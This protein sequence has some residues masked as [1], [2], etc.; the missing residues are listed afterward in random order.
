[1]SDMKIPTWA[2]GTPTEEMNPKDNSLVLPDLKEEHEEKSF[3][4]QLSKGRLVSGYMIA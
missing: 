4:S 2:K 1:M 3:M